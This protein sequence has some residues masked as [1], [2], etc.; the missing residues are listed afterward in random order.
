VTSGGKNVA[1]QP[2]ENVLKQ[3]PYIANAVVIG[4]SPE[5]YRCFDRPELR[6]A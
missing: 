2:I 6:K 4:G 3:N 5:I 1:P